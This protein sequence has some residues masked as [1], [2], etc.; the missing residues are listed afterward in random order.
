MS[1]R[2][3]PALD[4]NA[5]AAEDPPHRRDWPVRLLG[6]FLVLVVIGVTWYWANPVKKTATVFALLYVAAPTTIEPQDRAE[7]RREEVYRQTQ[8]GLLRT[9]A[10]LEQA[11]RSVADAGLSVVRE[12]SQP[13]EW[14]E[15]ELHVESFGKTK[16]IRVWMTG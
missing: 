8:A 5:P 10:V 3:R 12:Q 2:L 4:P 7:A 9:H 11:L 1:A 16:T 13:L 15:R 14:L 6:I